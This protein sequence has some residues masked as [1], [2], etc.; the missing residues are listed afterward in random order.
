MLKYAAGVDTSD[1]AKKTDLADWKSD[2][3]K[4]DIKQI[5]KFTK[6]LKQFENKGR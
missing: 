1:F 4:L 6:W 3:G 2:V 5:E